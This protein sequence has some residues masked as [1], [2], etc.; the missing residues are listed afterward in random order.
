MKIRNGFVS[1][2]SSSSFIVAFPR[3]PESVED[4]LDMMFGADAPDTV[5]AYGDYVVATRDVVD[6]IWHDVQQQLSRLPLSRIQIADELQEAALQ[7]TPLYG[8]VREL[9]ARGELPDPWSDWNTK[10]QQQRDRESA[11]VAAY[12]DELAAPVVEQ[13]LKQILTQ[14]AFV[15]Q[16]EYSDNDETL[17]IVM[18]HGEIFARLPHQRVSRH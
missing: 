10:S 12:Q 1:N 13:M 17:G 15:C 4:V 5:E 9:Q 7:S 6:Q 11:V 2:S 14:D 18:E 3:Q 8:K 16:F